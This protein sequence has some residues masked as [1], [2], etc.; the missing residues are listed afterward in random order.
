M[1]HATGYVATYV[2]G[3]KVAQN[4]TLTGKRPGRLVR[5]GRA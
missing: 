2:R 1:Q 5:V 3:V 4:G